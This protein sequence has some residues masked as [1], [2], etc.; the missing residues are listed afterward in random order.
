SSILLLPATDFVS[1]NI[2]IPRLGTYHEETDSASDDNDITSKDNKALKFPNWSR[3]AGIVVDVALSIPDNGWLVQA[4]T[5]SLIEESPLMDG[6]GII[7]LV[8]FFVP[9][10]VYGIMSGK[11]K[12]TKDLGK[13]L[14][15]SM[16]TMGSFIVIVFF[17]SQ[18]LAYLNWSNL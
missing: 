2:A 16:A 5:V 6:V 9:G 7:I 3:F 14:T 18:L 10:F 15:D 1:M 13:M 12:N 11:L 17:A 8:V 4:Q